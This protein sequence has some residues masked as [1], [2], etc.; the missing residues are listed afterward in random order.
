MITENRF[1]INKELV[2]FKR[3]KD[4]AFIIEVIYNSSLNIL[5][6]EMFY[7]KK[8]LPNIELEFFKSYN[9]KSYIL[10]HLESTKTLKPL[11]EFDI[12]EDF[13]LFFKIAI[14]ICKTVQSIHKNDIFHTNIT[15][16]TIFL[17]ENYNA[18][19]FNF[20]NSIDY[21]K[22]STGL[23]SVYFKNL[24]LINKSP[25]E[26]GRINNEVDLRSDIYNI[27]LTLYELV[28][29]QH[30]FKAK[31]DLET[32]HNILTKDIE[33]IENVPSN[34]SNLLIKTLKKEVLQRYQSINGLLYDLIQLQD[35]YT[36][37]YILGVND[38]SSRLQFPQKVYGRK[39]EIKNLV[40]KYKKVCKGKK[41]TIFISGYSGVGKS[42]LID[43]LKN[44]VINTN[45]YFISSKFDQYNKDLPY[46]AIS[47]AFSILVKQLLTKSEKELSQIKTSL[48]K[49]LRGNGQIL[50]DVVPSL[51]EIIG[52]QK[53]VNKLPANESE[54]RFNQVFLSFI[55]TVASKNTPLVLV[56][57][58][59]QWMDL[60]TLKL[61]ENIINE[62]DL[63][64]IFILAAYRSNEIKNNFALKNIIDNNK[65]I[66]IVE[67][68]SLKK[69]SLQK[70]LA[71]T[72]F[73][74][75]NEISLLVE[76][77]F[78]KTDA[79][80]FFFRQFIKKLY[81]DNLLFFSYE[82][83][84][85]DFDIKKIKEQNITD[86]VA[87][88]MLKNISKIEEPVLKYLQVA[89]CLG[90]TFDLKLIE[91]I[92]K[93]NIL[94]LLEDI[95][96]VFN[97]GF[98]IPLDIDINNK[99]EIEY[100]KVIKVKFLHDQVQQ[101][102]YSTIRKNE[103]ERLH[104]K[105]GKSL[106][107]HKDT[108]FNC[109]EI[110]SHLNYSK[111]LIQDEKEKYAL[112]DLNISAS[113]VAKASTAYDG[114]L[115]Y[116]DVA[117]SLLEELDFNK[118]YS[119]YIDILL[120]YVELLYLT[121]DFE[122]AKLYEDKLFSLINNIDDEIRLR[123]I[124]VVQ[125]TRIGRLYD[126]I[127]E[128]IKSLKLLGMDISK[129][130]TF[131]D[132]GA[133]IAE[134][135]VLVKETPFS[136]IAKLPKIEDSK[137][138]RT[139]DILMEMQPGSYNSG[140]LVFP[141]TILRLLKLTICNGNSSLSY[142]IYMMYALMNSKVLKDYDMAFE[143]SKYA[144]E[145]QKDYDK[146]ILTGR[147]NMML[148]NFVMPWQNKL[149]DS[150]DLRAQAYNEC[151]EFGDYYWGIHSYIFGFYAN[152]LTCKDLDELYSQTKTI[153]NV[154][155][156]INQVSQYYLCNMQMNLIKILNGKLDNY[157][158][159]N[160]KEG[161]EQRALEEYDKQNYMC[162]KYD[163][164]VARLI[165]GFMFE[166]Y[167]SALDISLDENLDESSLDEGIF[168]EA[169][170]KVF[171]ILSI[172]L[173]DINGKLKNESKRKRYY[174]Y[175]DINIKF[176]EIWKKNSPDLFVC[177]SSLINALKACLSNDIDSV[178]EEFENS[179]YEA[180]KYNFVFIEA[181]CNELY[182]NFWLK[183]GNTKISDTYFNE[184]IY[185]YK[186]FKAYAKVEYLELKLSSSYKKEEQN[187]SSVDLD[188][189]IKSSNLISKEMKLEKIVHNIL[190]MVY[191]FSGA[192]NGFMFLNDEKLNLAAQIDENTF[193]YHLEKNT[194]NILLPRSF[195]S[196]VSRLKE[197]V[198][199]NDIYSSEIGFEDDYINHNKPKSILAIPL[200]LNDE[201]KSII[202]LENYDQ[203]NI[204]SKN[205]IETIKLLTAQMVISIE[206]SYF[207]EKLESIVDKRTKD[208]EN[209]LSLF[210]MGQMLLFKWENK[211][212]WP[213]SY[214]SNNVA[215]ILGYE[216]EE[217]LEGKINYLDIIHNDDRRNVLNEVDEA[218]KNNEQIIV[219]KTYR[220]KNKKGSYLWVYD[221][222]KI[223]YDEKG[224]VSYFL[225]YIVDI[226][227]EKKRENYLLQQTKMIALGEMIGNIAHQWR[228]PLSLIST[229]ASSLKLKKELEI[230]KDDDLNESV[231]IIMDT[232][233]D[234][235]KTIDEFR[236][237]LCVDKTVFNEYYLSDIVSRAYKMISHFFINYNI[238]LHKDIQKGLKIKCSESQLVQ[239]FINILSNAKDALLLNNY[240]DEKIISVKAYKNLNKIHVSI[241]DNA[242]GISEE[243]L[244]KIFEPYFTTKHQSQGTGM[245]LYLTHQIITNELEGEI[246]VHNE[247]V[248]VNGK[249]Y[250]GACF[251]IHLS[252]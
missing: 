169:F 178:I 39:K 12:K 17:D 4:E 221:S 146:S 8:Y 232:V 90:A 203:K 172:L 2:L 62:D 28:T 137:L 30:P 119:L 131:E 152:L 98:L 198:L 101:A 120:D 41:E 104:Y 180:K 225:G 145:V 50:I 192:Q 25:E 33:F 113:N 14:N 71:D 102:V 250:K 105:I 168:H 240:N 95:K 35:D 202:Y 32:L 216:K 16:D 22:Q 154:S 231:E 83:F 36:K 248:L 236:D 220:I 80:P 116:L 63:E 130:I 65:N 189:I 92:E 49:N 251:S 93:I 204:F 200:V 140:S 123:R 219:H 37:D 133:E 20:S 179:I 107:S 183:K 164:I 1:F 47:E 218:S 68:K 151:L 207:Y 118:N 94:D 208:L 185:L 227:K 103:L 210:D 60:A 122:N 54:N 235:S 15:M 252:E 87:S 245:G 114:A 159:L 143:A 217:F 237:F 173:L 57:D 70:F 134:V 136:K 186:S 191:K 7:L 174:E 18:Y 19:I 228:Q 117:K 96:N 176:I 226:T 184:A 139:L 72:L 158:N 206:N 81:D 215:S 88:F 148:A 194:E 229:S 138:L 163:F 199:I 46:Y 115:V 59:L 48:L 3:D 64:Y 111:S 55:K 38:I 52:E 188:V 79:N 26:L 205:S 167:E 112:V 40:K 128:G 242:G 177:I 82:A 175:I 73:L 125:Y 224:N 243:I 222:T 42:S 66:E 23:S 58:D 241:Q 127:D 165:Q 85:W 77:V 6:K 211:S 135:Q 153:A 24:P 239:V 132:V 197:I 124:L 230:L 155:K 29:K 162:G 166:N 129:D 78:L 100:A 160:H 13:E 97:N 234:L 249:I 86:N 201:V 27:G 182:A 142:Y 44:K 246:E 53:E 61:L 171:N 10:F 247:N 21:T 121:S 161:F 157:I 213:V 181:I 11:R 244:E 56:V 69:S 214:L 31:D 43:E 195:I 109:F 150:K 212:N 147:V 196:Y 99:N 106:I 126:S 156:K 223:V 5:E 74:Q 9:E 84:R 149:V 67:L 170:Y 34:I 45:S 91:Q 190:E 233:Q 193:V 144:Q 141:I 209:T 108:E 89:S 110:L 76:E 238:K 75:K 187:S 51:V